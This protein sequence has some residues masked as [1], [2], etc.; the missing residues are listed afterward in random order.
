MK[1]VKELFRDIKWFAIALDGHPELQRTLRA[2]RLHRRRRQIAATL[3]I[4]VATYAK[5]FTRI[6]QILAPLLA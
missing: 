1:V 3:R 2:I 4:P 6:C 5:R